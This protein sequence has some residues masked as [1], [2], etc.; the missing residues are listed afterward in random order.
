MK[1][2]GMYD[3][4][5]KTAIVTGG[6]S[7]IGRSICLRL[8]AEGADV[9]VLDYNSDGAAETA[10]LAAEH[11]ALA[12]SFAVDVSDEASVDSAIADVRAWRGDV[13]IL[14]N[15][16]GIIAIGTVEE[17]STEEWRRVFAVNVD[18]VFHTCRAV[19]PAM[20]ARGAGKIIN[21]SSWFGKSGKPNYAAYSASKAAVMGLT[22]SLAMELASA[23]VNVNAVCPGTI[24]ETGMRDFADKLSAEKNLS[25]AKERAKSIPMGRVGKPEDISRVV[26]F[27]ASDE[28]DYMTG[29]SINVTGGLLFH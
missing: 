14:V 20:R 29:Q 7:G 12:R 4:K 19:A 11:G 28:A 1:G 6:A 2:S 10:V 22:Q 23:G 13:D 25:T 9:A 5:G 21:M 15:C 27:L 24:F 26:A 16:A 18:G 17:T 8:A 3:L